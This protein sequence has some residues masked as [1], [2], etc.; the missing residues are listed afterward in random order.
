MRVAPERAAF[1]VENTVVVDAFS[2]EVAKA[3]G[4]HAAL[5]RFVADLAKDLKDLPDFEYRAR[6]VVDRM[7]LTLQASRLIR[8]APALV[9]DAFCHS[10]L[11]QVGHHNYSTLPRGCD[12][13][14]PSLRARRPSASN[15]ALRCWRIDGAG[16]K[17]KVGN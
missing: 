7:A 2:T 10:R 17:L 4:A 11:G 5:D 12:A 15:D 6:N 8:S 13:P 16:E 3:Q 9:S 1:P 14:P